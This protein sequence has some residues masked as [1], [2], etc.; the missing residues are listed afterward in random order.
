MKCIG[1]QPE[2]KPL[3]QLAQLAQLAHL[4]VPFSTRL[5]S[6]DLFPV[7]APLAV[8]LLRSGLRT[9]SALVTHLRSG[10]LGLRLSPCETDSGCYTIVTLP[11][12]V[13]AIGAMHLFR[14]NNQRRDLD[15]VMKAFIMIMINVRV[16]ARAIAR[17]SDR[18]LLAASSRTSEVG[19]RA[20]EQVRRV[21]NQHVS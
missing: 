4:K 8:S 20:P 2:S 17:A 5:P 21:K 14:L 7:S 15:E 9:A 10:S 13:I 6:L 19:A 1:D 12:R 16:Q 3:A 11:S 18:Y